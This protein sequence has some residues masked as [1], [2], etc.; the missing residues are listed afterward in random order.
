MLISKKKK[1]ITLGVKNIGGHSEL[2]Q[3][4]VKHHTVTLNYICY[5]TGWLVRDTVSELQHKNYFL[6]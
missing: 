5:C 2:S 1:V 6:N 3:V 4:K